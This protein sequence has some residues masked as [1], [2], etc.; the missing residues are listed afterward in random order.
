MRTKIALLVA[1][2]VMGGLAAFLAARYLNEARTAIVEDAEPVEV[3]VAQEDI[4][5]GLSAE[6]MIAEEVIALE[7]VPR[8]FV[9]AGAVS[10][11]AALEGYVLASPL[12]AGEQLTM[13]RF[14]LPA[15]AGVSYSIPDGQL[16]LSIPVD[17]VTGV[18][19][20]VKPGDR[21]ALYAHLVTGPGGQLNY[22]KLLVPECKVVAAGGALR[23]R[24]GEGGDGGD[25]EQ[26]GSLLASRE[27]DTSS[28]TPV[29]TQTL[30]IA[31]SPEDAE[32]VVW[33][34]AQSRSSQGEIWAAI[35]PAST[36]EPPTPVGTNVN[37][38]FQ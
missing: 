5:R 24:V 1:A 37:T 11:K 33:A 29:D 36:E 6:E 12:T 13:A 21:V 14:E 27:D 31:L 20:L 18:S 26:A 30:T 10:S 35:L 3:L 2:L 16:A 34:S 15:A 25:E 38:I 4:P 19:G 23:A 8:R 9:A 32:R 17:V 22:T 28:D 7:K